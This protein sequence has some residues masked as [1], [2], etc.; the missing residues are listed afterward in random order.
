MGSAKR[1]KGVASA[2]RKE[3][4][5]LPEGLLLSDP[6]AVADI[7]K[8]LLT[9][10]KLS[11]LT[12]HV[13]VCLPPEQVL[14]TEVRFAFNRKSDRAA[15]LQ[16][17]ITKALPVPLEDLV[18]TEQALFRKKREH[19]IGVSAVSRE[20][21]TSVQDTCKVAGVLPRCITSATSA[22]A[23]VLPGDWSNMLLVVE[24]PV[25]T[26]TLFGKRV[27]LD[28]SVLL[29]ESTVEEILGE[30]AAILKSTDERL[31]P[32]HA[33]VIGSAA[34][35]KKLAER[36]KKEGLDIP[37]NLFL[38]HLYKENADVLPALAASLIKKGECLVDLGK[39]VAL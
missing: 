13:A 1:W 23:S 7:L 25:P 3:T 37:C 9:S 11:A 21:I 38:E 12:K 24:K 29:T 17:A 6:A 8:K 35:Q 5:P 18:V 2:L 39:A 10:L 4:A 36:L 34:F 19:T 27:P 33:W 22:Y 31:H 20:L 26:V 16:T 30:A 15:A 14:S 32:T 28:E